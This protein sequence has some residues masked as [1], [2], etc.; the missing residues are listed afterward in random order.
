MQTPVIALGSALCRPGLELFTPLG[1]DLQPVS[2]SSAI[3]EFSLGVAFMVS[4]AAFGGQQYIA[5]NVAALTCVVKLLFNRSTTSPTHGL[6]VHA[7]RCQSVGPWFEPR[8]RS[9]IEKPHR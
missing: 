1:F 2:A 4:L 9:H 8:S 7:L 6:P 5:A 3:N